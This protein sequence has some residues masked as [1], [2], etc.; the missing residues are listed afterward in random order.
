ML[1]TWFGRLLNLKYL[2]TSLCIGLTL[3]LI[4]QELVN[5]V[6]IR[7]TSN[8]F[9]EKKLETTDIPEVVLC[10]DPGFNSK[11]LNKYGY[12]AV[13]YYRGTMGYRTPFVG[14]NGGENETKSSQEI[15]EEAL[16][17]ESRFLNDSTLVGALFTGDHV[18]YIAGESNL[19]TLA[20]PFGLCRSF[21][22]PHETNLSS[23]H[24]GLNT[25]AFQNSS[26]VTIFLMDKTNSLRM[27]PKELEM[28]GDPI[29]IKTHE[30]STMA[31][32]AIRV[33][34]FKHV[35]GD[36]LFICT[37]YTANYSYNDCVRDEMLNAIEEEIGCQPPLIAKDLKNMCNKRFNVSAA[38]SLRLETLLKP[39]YYKDKSFDCRTPC[40]KKVFN[41]KHVQ[42]TPS[43]MTGVTYL[44][45]AFDKI[46]EVDNSDF[47]IDSQT[48]LARLGG[49]ISSG[50]TLLW[51]LVSLLGAA[52]VMFL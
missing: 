11:V 46:L 50:R 13:T 38:Q 21:T 10:V 36:P 31:L 33:S 34:Q 42:T 8:S 18:K 12:K 26:K 6:I 27:Y 45:L 52:Q 15:L 17:P 25:S 23:I 5:F 22:P 19:R 43:G 32:Y 44:I 41:I 29:E 28:L 14:W 39:L 51:I 16:T 3:L 24:I 9:E 7:P 47:S 2:F 37:V 35:A 48:F 49:S 40:T 30:T 20:Y 1:C 4:Y